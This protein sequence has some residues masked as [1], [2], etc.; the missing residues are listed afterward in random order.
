[1]PSE[2]RG[3]RPGAVDEQMKALSDPTRR[4]ILHLVAER[5]IAA[6][7][8]A[9][10][11]DLTR[12]AVSQHLMVLLD[13]GLLSVREDGTR[14]LY[15]TDRDSLRSMFE[16]LDEYWSLGLVRLQRAAERGAARR[17]RSKRGSR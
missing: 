13:A 15:S 4:E 2:S 6:S 14:R 16:R 9:S 7:D 8:V 12:P 10:A 3:G 5:E 17:R 11:F 1:M